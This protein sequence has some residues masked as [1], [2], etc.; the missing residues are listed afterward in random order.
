MRPGTMADGRCA[1]KCPVRDRLPRTRVS[2]FPLDLLGRALAGGF[3]RGRW[4]KPAALMVDAQIVCEV[5]QEPAA[6]DKPE[7]WIVAEAV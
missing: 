6:N 2:V 4:I 5:E 7:P 1:V 3:A